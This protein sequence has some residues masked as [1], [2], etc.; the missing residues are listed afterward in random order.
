MFFVGIFGINNRSKIKKEVSFKCTGCIE[1]KGELIENYSSFELFFIPVYKFKRKYFLRCQSCESLYWL[2]DESIDNILENGRVVYE[3]IKEVIYQKE[4]CPRCN[5]EIR[6][7][8]DYC[9]SC[10]HKL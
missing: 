1:T 7:N 2:K 8:C 6:E 5:K 3:N 9:P 10:G 4:V